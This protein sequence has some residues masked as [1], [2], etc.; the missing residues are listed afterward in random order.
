ML[1]THGQHNLDQWRSAIATCFFHAGFAQAACQ[2]AAKSMHRPGALGISAVTGACAALNPKHDDH[3]RSAH[4]QAVWTYQGYHQSRPSD[5]IHLDQQVQVAA[6]LSLDPPFLG[7]APL[8]T[9]KVQ[10][11]HPTPGT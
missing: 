8:L 6:E 7:G 10:P 3:L 11:E 5:V 4:G 9:F 1:Q 2:Q